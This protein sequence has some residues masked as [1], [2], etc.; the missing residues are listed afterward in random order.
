MYELKRVDYQQVEYLRLASHSVKNRDF[1]G[2]ARMGN[3]AK[4]RRRLRGMMRSGQ[5]LDGSEYSMVFDWRGQQS[6]LA[7]SAFVSGIGVH[8]GEIANLA[9]HPA[10]VDSGIVFKRSFADG[11]AIT[12][13]AISS[14]VAHTDL[15]TAIGARGHSIAT[16]EHVMAAIYACGIDNLVVEVDCGEVPILDG[17]AAPF[18][19]L[20]NEAGIITQEAPRRYIRVR[21][22]V[23]VEAGASWAEFQPYNGTRFEIEIDFD[24]A[25]IGRQT[26]AADITAASFRRELARARTF[27]FLRN[28]ERLWATGHALGS[29]LENSVVIGHDERVINPDGLRFSDEFVRHKALDAVGDLA[30]AGAQFIG[31]FRSYRGG[32][33]VNAK[34]LRTLLSDPTA[35]E[36]VEPRKPGSF[37]RGGD[38][39]AVMAPV[40]APWML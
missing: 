17:S 18:I 2:H 5:D 32:H 13:P 27:G 4:I 10:D 40:F 29:S 25:A 24:C 21:K 31:S 30:L 23:R 12:I 34:A 20:I 37:A 26:F 11:N 35:F 19:D 9:L 6:T 3:V 14:S 33:G 16:V 1:S 36:I 28:V 7:R 15:C 39:V 8:S 22:P 38:M